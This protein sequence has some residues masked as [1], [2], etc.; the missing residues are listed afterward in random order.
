MARLF[1]SYRTEDSQHY[2]AYLADRLTKGLPEWSIFRDKDSIKPGARWQPELTDQVNAATTFLVVIGPTWLQLKDVHGRRLID[3]DNDWVR[4]EVKQALASGKRVVPILVNGAHLPKA[5]A[6]PHDIMRL[7]ELQAVHLKIEP[8][9][10]ESV[11]GRRHDVDELIEAIADG[12]EK[13]RP[14]STRP[15]VLTTVGTGV[16]GAVVA[17]LP[18]GSVLAGAVGGAGAAVI[19]LLA[20][21]WGYRLVD[22]PAPV[23]TGGRR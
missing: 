3:G 5:D 22:R 13:P 6:L 20:T 2:V 10:I 18:Q 16:L 11:Q 15:A 19:C 12:F 8:E 23:R 1:I 14:R 4:W 17:W 7:A 21:H 9:E